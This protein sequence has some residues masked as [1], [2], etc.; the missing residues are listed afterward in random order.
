MCGATGAQEQLQQSQME[1]YNEATQQA[2]TAF[3]EDQA[4]LKGLEDVYSPIL[5]KGPN[6]KGFSTEQEN[7]LNASAVEGTATSYQHAA[8]ALN[9]QLAT[10]GGGNIAMPTGG[11]QQ[12]K[13]ELAA[14]SAGSE[15]QQLTHI[16]EA[17]YAQGY[18][19]F[20]L[21]TNALSEASG[22]LN[23]ASYDNA[24]TGAGSAAEKTASDIA[25]ENSS[26]VNA[27]LGAVGSLG[28]A[29]VSENPGNV[30]G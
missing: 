8:K 27:A 23:P 21:A 3:G 17:D 2:R 25:A 6:Q 28:S 9:E 14:A 1:F 18:D 30:F 11:Q 20:K 7:D 12:L 22:R 15:A 19:E 16:K 5:A 13:A 4:I 10:E 24:A 29:V 26:W